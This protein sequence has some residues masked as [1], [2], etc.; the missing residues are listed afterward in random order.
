MPITQE[1]LNEK[2]YILTILKPEIKVVCRRLQPMQDQTTPYKPPMAP[3]LPMKNGH[4][5]LVRIPIYF[6]RTRVSC[7][8][9]L[10]SQ[11]TSA[12]TT[13]ALYQGF[14]MS[15]F[16]GVIIPDNG[17]A[18]ISYVFTKSVKPELI[19]LVTNTLHHP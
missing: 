8:L 16:P 4:E 12:S 3:F 10:P 19:Q 6:T 11:N 18:F 2:N 5:D 1:F 13:A 14:S 7:L 17:S 15:I 9:W